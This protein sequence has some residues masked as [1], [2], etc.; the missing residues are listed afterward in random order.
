MIRF[1][2]VHKT[3]LPGTPDARLLLQ[4]FQLHIEKGEFVMLLGANGAGKSTLFHLLAGTES[5]DRGQI[6]IEG[7]DV[8]AQSE[9]QRAKWISRVFQDPRQ[10]SA[11]A[12]TIEENLA[13]ALRRGLSR[14]LRG[15]RDEA[16]NVAS[17]LEALGMGLESRLCDP[18]SL[19]SGGQRQ[20]VT[21]RM[22][23]LLRPKILLLDEH[24]AA[25]DPRAEASVLALTARIVAEQGLTALMITHN[26]SHALRY[27]NR[28]VMLRGGKIALDIT[29]KEKEALQL[30]ELYAKFGAE[31]RT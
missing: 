10:G 19:L 2:G 21:L 31:E 17:A 15:F 23:T 4:D 11:G 1:L 16:Y 18:M 13:L 25:L 8:T 30:E 14:R 9:P 22:A 6:W 27:G 5:V 12:L 29:G 24:T 3:F 26:L 7:V 28:L 20:A